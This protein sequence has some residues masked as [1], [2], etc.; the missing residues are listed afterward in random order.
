MTGRPLSSLR[1]EKVLQPKLR[2][3]WVF[4]YDFGPNYMC[5]VQCQLWLGT[6]SHMRAYKLA[7]RLL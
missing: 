6:H 2:Y 1:T 5:L 7:P 3:S 4:E